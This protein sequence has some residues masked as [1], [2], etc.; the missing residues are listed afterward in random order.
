MVRIL[1][2]MLIIT[3]TWPAVALAKTPTREAAINCFNQTVQAYSQKNESELRAHIANQIDIDSLAVRVANRGKISYDQALFLATEA[4][5]GNSSTA[6]RNMDYKTVTF[7]RYSRV[8]KGPKQTKGNPDP[9]IE[10][11]GYY[12]RKD[13]RDREDREN[14]TA[15]LRI[16]GDDCQIVDIAYNNAWLS[17]AALN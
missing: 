10:V 7:N 8:I 12:Y 15:I 4:V 6:F 11:A 3:Y 9:V 1:V 2:L 17:A 13:D 16:V 5:N 14:F